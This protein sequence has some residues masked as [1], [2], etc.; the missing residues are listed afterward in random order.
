VAQPV[1]VAQL[2]VVVRVRRV[3]VLWV[4]IVVR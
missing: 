2:V 4:R 1:E 3:V